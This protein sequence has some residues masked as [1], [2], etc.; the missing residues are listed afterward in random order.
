[1]NFLTA[2]I[3]A[4][5]AGVIGPQQLSL[6]AAPRNITIQANFTYVASAATSVDAYFQTSLDN[7]ATWVDVAE[8]N[9]TTASARKIAN[10][11]A[12]T[13]K[14][15]LVTP[16]DGSLSANTCVDGV[17]GPLFRVKYTS[18][19]TYGAGTTLA[20]DVATDQVK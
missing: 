15:T 13:P 19:G 14:T 2:T 9:F 16:T 6:N 3:T 18:V 4:A 20:I 12:L 10:L 8:F 11:S 17:L 7:G 1:M 5:A